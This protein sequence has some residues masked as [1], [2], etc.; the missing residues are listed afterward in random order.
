M[1][2]PITNDRLFRSEALTDQLGRTRHTVGRSS[3][4]LEPRGDTADGQHTTA[5][6]PTFSLHP[7]P[8]EFVPLRAA[9]ASLRVL[10]ANRGHPCSWTP[11]AEH[12]SAPAVARSLSPPDR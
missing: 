2:L 10:A 3:Q 8:G 7:A 5:T 1:S 4:R 9:L 6:G 12:P 11:L